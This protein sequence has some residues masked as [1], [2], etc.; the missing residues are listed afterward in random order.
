MRSSGNGRNSIALTTIYGIPY[1]IKTL[2]TEGLW[3]PS[4]TL[5]KSIKLIAMGTWNCLLVQ[6]H[7]YSQEEYTEYGLEGGNVVQTF[8]MVDMSQ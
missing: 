4:N 2:P 5:L 8:L 3:V 7:Q 6:D 1:E